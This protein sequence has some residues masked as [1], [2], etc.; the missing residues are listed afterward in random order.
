MRFVNVYGTVEDLEVQQPTIPTTVLVYN[1]THLVWESG[2]G[3]ARLV[4]LSSRPITFKPY[5]NQTYREGQFVNGSRV[6]YRGSGNSVEIY[7]EPGRLY[8]AQAFEF[9]GR[10][11]TEVYTVGVQSPIIPPTDISYLLQENGDFLLQEN[12]FKILV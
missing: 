4:V 5:K 10:A 9:N 2:D 8:Y 7:L 6:V 11:S 3:D 12:G 1:G